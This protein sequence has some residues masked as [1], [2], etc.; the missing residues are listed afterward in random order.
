MLRL[1]RDFRQILIGHAQELFPYECCGVLVGRTKEGEKIVTELCQTTNI[2]AGEKTD[3][4][5]IE[6]KELMK[7]F[8]RAAEEEK[9]VLG[10]YHSHPNGSPIPSRSDSEQ[11]SWSFYSYVIVGLDNKGEG[12]IKS[13]VF[14]EDRGEFEEEELVWE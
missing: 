1:K 9:D 13:W 3:W 11:V 6:P 5:E 7:I 2:V 10:F 12:D 4:F 14:N 8:Q